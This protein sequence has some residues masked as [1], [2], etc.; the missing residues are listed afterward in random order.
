MNF[1]V[2]CLDEP[3]THT[4]THLQTNTGNCQWRSR[5]EMVTFT[6]DLANG[7]IQP[8]HIANREG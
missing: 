1:A 3:H 2:V 7:C 8:L 6:A 5:S 4:R